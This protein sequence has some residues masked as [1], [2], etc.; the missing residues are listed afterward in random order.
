MNEQDRSLGLVAYL[1]IPHLASQRI[2]VMDLRYDMTGMEP[3]DKLFIVHSELN[4]PVEDQDENDKED[5]GSKKYPEGYSA[6]S[7]DHTV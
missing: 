2:I 7:Q 6:D 3:A 4:E 5:Q 1:Y